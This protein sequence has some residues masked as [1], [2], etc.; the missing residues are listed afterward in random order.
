MNF[1]IWCSPE[2]IFLDLAGQ[3]LL[4]PEILG[5][6]DAENLAKGSRMRQHPD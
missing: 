2:R 1:A 5:C 6:L 4:C 3:L